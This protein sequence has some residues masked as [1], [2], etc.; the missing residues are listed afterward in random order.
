VFPAV[1]ADGRTVITLGSREFFWL[2]LAR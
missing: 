1:G 2:T